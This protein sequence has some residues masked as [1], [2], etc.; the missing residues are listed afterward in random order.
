M[1]SLYRYQD[2]VCRGEKQLS[3]RPSYA[4][5]NSSHSYT[6]VKSELVSSTWMVD[7]WG[8]LGAAVMGSKIGA[9]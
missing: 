1:L 9:A 3:Q 2:L 5:N 6:V 7:P 8:T 4:A